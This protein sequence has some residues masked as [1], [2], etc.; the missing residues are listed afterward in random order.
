M[1]N[2]LERAR[3]ILELESRAI[4]NIPLNDKLL[5]AVSLLS[6]T[7][8]KVVC[9]GMGKAG[10]IARKVAATF[11]ST[12]TAAVFLH[13]G[14]A[15]HGDLGM[16]CAGDVLLVFSNSGKTREAIE[17]V[18]LARRLYPGA[19]QVI[20]IT[21]DAASALAQDSDIALSIGQVQEACALGMAPT[22]STTAM[23]ALG[24]VL[25]VLAMEE[26]SFTH[27]DFLKRHHGGY[28]GQQKPSL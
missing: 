23:L 21:S 7:G 2:K 18:H 26:K 13:P 17:L 16:L 15:Q 1:S 4:Q 11:S 27:E 25:C 20:T 8:G 19:L 3:Q 6:T 10:I 12:G 14:E 22:S 28:L 9:S 5:Q 24:D